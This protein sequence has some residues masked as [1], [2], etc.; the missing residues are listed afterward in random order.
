MEGKKQKRNEVTI[1]NHNIRFDVQRAMLVGLVSFSQYF[2]LNIIFNKEAYLITGLHSFF[3][4]FAWHQ[5]GKKTK[6]TEWNRWKRNDHINPIIRSF[7]AIPPA[8]FW[9]LWWVWTSSWC[10]SLRYGV[11]QH[12]F[13]LVRNVPFRQCAKDVNKTQR[14]WIV[15]MTIFI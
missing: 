4:P 15:H 1:N 13:E 10:W 11:Q 8:P 7:P 6:P 3:H 12:P 5:K 9:I 14:S 2:V